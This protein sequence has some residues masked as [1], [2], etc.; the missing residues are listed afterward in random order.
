[1]SIAGLTDPWPEGPFD[2]VTLVD[3]LHHVP[4]DGQRAFIGRLARAGARQVIV[5]DVDTRPRWKV[6]AN[7][8]HDFLMTRERVFPRSM[9]EV[10]AWLREDGL[11]VVRAERMGRLC[12]SHWLVVAWTQPE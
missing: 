9:D 6:W 8:L 2:V 4:P 11:K 12:Y 5:K 3:V 7:A 1:M 10:V